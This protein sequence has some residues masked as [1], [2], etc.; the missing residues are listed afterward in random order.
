MS[1]KEPVAILLFIGTL[2]SFPFQVH[3]YFSTIRK[4]RG[5]KRLGLSTCIV[6]A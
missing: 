1:F 6:T 2:P 5:I 4:A 3:I